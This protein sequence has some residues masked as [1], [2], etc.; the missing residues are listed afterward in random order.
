MELRLRINLE[1]SKITSIELREK[2]GY[3]AIKFDIRY[4]KG[5]ERNK[6]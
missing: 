3:V 1:L 2:G 4:Q 6:E 5:G